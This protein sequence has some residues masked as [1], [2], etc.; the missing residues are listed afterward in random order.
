MTQAGATV[1]A[2]GVTRIHG[3][4]GART[5]AL[6]GVDLAVAP[7]EFVA[8]LGPSGSGKSTLLHLLAGLDR[9]TSGS[10]CVDGVDLAALDDQSRTLLRRRRIG[11]V[12]QSFYLVESLTAEENVALPLALDGVR[13]AEASRRAQRALAAVGLEGRLRHRPTELSGGEQQ[14]VAVAR[15]LVIEPT[16]L[17]ADEP[18]GNLDS[19]A[20]ARVLALLRGLAGQRRRTIVLVTHDPAQGALADRTVWLR[21]GRLAPSGPGEVVTEGP[22]LAAVRKGQVESRRAA[23]R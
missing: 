20:A 2:R 15:A 22:A 4:A 11:M 9:P 6:R 7:G 1:V 18:T 19:A 16:L 10:V 17:L 3:D 5:H 13:P 14:R 8:L 21:D 23:R 12:F